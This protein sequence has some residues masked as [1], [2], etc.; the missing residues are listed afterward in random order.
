[1]TPRETQSQHESV[2]RFSTSR[3]T[4]GNND[5]EL[6]SAERSRNPPLSPARE[7]IATSKLSPAA[8][9]MGEQRR[10]SIASRLSDPRSANMSSEE[11]LPA[12]ERLSVNTR[13]T[14]GI[15]LS[16]TEVTVA[17]LNDMLLADSSP[18][19]EALTT[20]TRPSSSNIFGNGRLGPCERSPI[21]T[22]SEDR[23]HVSLRLGP[24]RDDEED[25]EDGAFDLQLQQALSS[26]AAGKRIATQSKEKKRTARSSPINTNVKRRRTTKAHPSPRRKLMV[27][28]ITAGGRTQTK[29]R[30]KTAPAMTIIPPR[31]RKESGFRPLQDSLP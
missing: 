29:K 23:V 17:P 21:R 15:D 8:L 16:E 9:P 31:V 3:R 14:S 6:F 27:D 13:R 18:G 5:K 26:K 20:V 1:M 24:L 11:R 2:E 7:A 25:N 28:A 30:Q 10:G 22:L 19:A 12:K 4:Q